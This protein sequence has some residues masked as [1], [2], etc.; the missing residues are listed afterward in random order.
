MCIRLQ[1]HKG[2]MQSH[3]SSTCTAC[4]EPGGQPQTKTC[5]DPCLFTQ[6]GR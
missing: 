6:Q 2:I 1:Y 3:L 5:S 4:G